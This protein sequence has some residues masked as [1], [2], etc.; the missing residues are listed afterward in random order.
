MSAW[1][2]AVAISSVCLTIFLMYFEA[3]LI[4]RFMLRSLVLSSVLSLRSCCISALALRILSYYT[5]K[6]ADRAACS[7]S[8]INKLALTA[9]NLS[10]SLAIYTARGFLV[11]LRVFR[12]PL[13]LPSFMLIFLMILSM[14]LN[15]SSIETKALPISVISPA[16]DGIV[17]TNTASKKHIKDNFITFN[18]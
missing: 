4:S 10:L 3:F 11:N 6:R 18:Y 7:F 1:M 8:L 15:Y 9:F 16:G 13:S 12:A 14:F 5:L 17:Y 2:E